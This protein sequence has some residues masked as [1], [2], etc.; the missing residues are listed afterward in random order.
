MSTVVIVGVGALGS[1][2]VLLARNWSA[3]LKLVDFDRVEQKN[4][5]AQ[6]HSKMGLGRNKA[7]ALGQAMQGMFGLKV[8]SLPRK[9]RSNLARNLT[10]SQSGIQPHI[11]PVSG[12]RNLTISLAVSL[13]SSSASN[14]PGSSASNSSS[15]SGR[16]Q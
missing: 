3:K 7:Q 16:S 10:S 12:P 8:D 1:H 4:T 15:T 2:L 14:S 11:W 13:T 5:Q 9:L 6:F